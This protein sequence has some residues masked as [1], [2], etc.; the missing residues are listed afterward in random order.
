MVAA[1]ADLEL[2]L[3]RNASRKTFRAEL[4]FT[5]TLGVDQ[6][7]SVGSLKIDRGALS[8]SVDEQAYGAALTDMLF[9]PEAVSEFYTLAVAAAQSTPV[10]FR[11]RIEGAPEY[12]DVRWELLHDPTN[13]EQPVATSKNMLFSRYLG[14]KDWRPVEAREL[15]SPRALIVIANPADLSSWRPDGR[16]LHPVDVEGELAKA[17]TALAG[18]QLEVLAGRGDKDTA[19]SMDNLI[20]RLSDG[21]DILYLVAHG[22]LLNGLPLIFL[23]DENGALA[24]PP[25]ARRLI[26]HVRDLA[27]PPSMIFLSSCQSAGMQSEDGGALAALGPGLADA[28]VPAVIAMQGNITMRTA[29]DFAPAFFESFRQDGVVDR[30]VA[31][32]R[33]LIRDR[34]DWWMPVLFSRLRWGQTRYLSEFTD[35]ESGAGAW[36]N[37]GAMIERDPPGLTPV[38]GP[39]LA[40]GIIGSRQE[41]ALRW[42]RRWNMPIAEHAHGDLA[43]VAQYLRVDSNPGRPATELQRYLR[44]DL[45]E[46]RR[47]AQGEDPF[48]ALNGFDEDER[49]DKTIEAVGKILRD[50]DDG[51]PYRVVAAL[52]AEVFVTTGW[53]DLLQDAL[54]DRG[55]Q[56]VTASFRWRPDFDGD[57]PRRKTPVPAPT[58]GSPLVYHLFGRLDDLY[59]L[60]LTEDDYFEW[61]TAW[62]GNRRSEIPTPVKKALTNA[63]LLF[64]GYQL[65]DWDF[66]VV[67]QSIK[68]FP[69]GV[70]TRRFQHVGVQLKPETQMIEPEAAQR[71]LN[72][73]FKEDRV[74]IYW[75]DT[76]AFLK[77]LRRRT[78]IAT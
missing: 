68:S 40:D 57:R 67:F 74:D 59:S 34:P 47:N 53:T 56:P 25:D 43:Q 32:A 50:R 33:G 76:R 1:F 52:P 2:S 51:D 14:S 44:T 9:G 78:G 17:Q 19:P 39:G 27:R 58:I 12:H 49:P 18:Y 29:T 37:L 41:I 75:A 38:L 54:A 3:I 7:D 35:A 60:V 6:I 30:A 11:L 48:A 55:K 62:V 72:S 77:E 15:R 69:G 73:Y 4:H 61:L 26:A 63:S 66:R 31:M 20:S 21:F 16:E 28:G 5:N 36:D 70:G 64:L 22:A 24:A 8:E 42:V 46:R 65:D 10:H 45:A 23:E 13:R 71:Y